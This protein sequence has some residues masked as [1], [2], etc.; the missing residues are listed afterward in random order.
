MSAVYITKG[1]MYLAVGPSGDC[2]LIE[3]GLVKAASTV[4]A[5]KIAEAQDRASDI[6]DDQ[7][8]VVALP[9][10][11]P[12]VIMSLMR[13]INMQLTGQSLRN[14]L[15]G[16]AINQLYELLVAA[17]KY[18]CVDVLDTEGQEPTASPSSTSLVDNVN[19]M[20]QF[21]CVSHQLGYVNTYEAAVRQLT[22][23]FL[24]STLRGAW[25]KI[26]S[27]LLPKHFLRK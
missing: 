16:L 9:S 15:G 14:F 26:D 12:E 20:L 25:R 11:E 7:K 27:S 18:D 19:C 3:S 13:I 24:M 21:A 1:D 6:I 4:L 17:K 10:D 5:T 2:I 22:L 23:S 8:P